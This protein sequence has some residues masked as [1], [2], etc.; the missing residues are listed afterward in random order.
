MLHVDSETICRSLVEF[1]KCSP[2]VAQCQCRIESIFARVK[3]LKFNLNR[4]F[5]QTEKIYWPKTC[6]Q[7]N[8]DTANPEETLS[9][10][11]WHLTFL[12]T[13]QLVNDWGSY[14]VYQCISKTSYSSNDV[15]AN[16]K[17]TLT[18]GHLHLTFLTTGQ[19]VNDWGSYFVYQ[20]TAFKYSFSRQLLVFRK[21]QRYICV[22]YYMHRSMTLLIKYYWGQVAN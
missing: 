18:C 14:F 13:G 10:G 2:I 17:E 9:C 1:V 20:S 16:H 4:V 8:D 12:T 3:L 5:I 21:S 19:L 11:H 6:Y 15:T 7:S 22:V